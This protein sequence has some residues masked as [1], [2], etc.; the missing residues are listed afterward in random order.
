[1]KILHIITG[2]EYGGAERLLVN[3][4]NLQA[5]DHEI[6]VIYFKGVPH[7]KN[8]FNRDITIINIPYNIYVLKNLRTYL[9]N[10]NPDVIHTHLGHA[11]L[12][13]MLASIGLKSK[14]VCTMHN[15]WF[16]RNSLDYLIFFCYFVLFK[17]ITSNHSVICISKS[18]YDHVKNRLGVSINKIFL[19]YNAIPELKV[20]ESK[21]ELRK[22]LGFVDDQFVVLFVG[23][24]SQQKSV[25]TLIRCAPLLI[26][27]I[28]NLRIILVGEGKMENELRHLIEQLSVENH[29][30]FRGV[31]EN[32]EYYFKASDIFVLPSIFEGFG[33]VILEAF[34]ASLPVI[35]TNIEGPSELIVNHKNGLLFRPKDYIM[36]SEQILIMYL[37]VNLRKEMALSGYETYEKKFRMLKYNS[38]INEIYNVKSNNTTYY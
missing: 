14:L 9:V 10:N 24:L 30:E 11:D 8:L 28:P 22:L 2:L 32:P 6:T 7:L 29:V 23:R 5:L 21:A 34:R 38:D 12:I 3:L 26:E 13:G 35:A 31:V 19:V 36:L 18:V 27:K 16:K 25:S 33:I 20:N 15:I 4:T 37:N 17:F 1:M